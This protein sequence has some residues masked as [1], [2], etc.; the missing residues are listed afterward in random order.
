[1]IGSYECGKELLVQRKAGNFLTNWVAVGI[2]MT[3]R[4]RLLYFV[5]C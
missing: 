4:C 2:S 3:A 1:M 5:T